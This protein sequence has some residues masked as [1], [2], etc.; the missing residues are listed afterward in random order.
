MNLNF[1]ASDTP[2]LPSNA[3]DQ[4]MALKLAKQAIKMSGIASPPISVN[5]VVKA[6]QR[7]GHK[8]IVKSTPLSDGFSG[9]II[10][11]P[12][13]TGIMY[14]STHSQHR[15]RYTVAHELGHFMMN[16][17]LTATYKEVVNLKNKLK[18]EK[19]ANIFAAELL[20]PK[21][22]IKNALKSRKYTAKELATL[23]DVSEEAMWFKIESDSLIKYL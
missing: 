22:M 21:E 12:Q 7:F 17:I 9:Q 4:P 8:I 1:E 6:L 11:M 2:S 14:N 18:I 23:F 15:Q 13:I 10:Q 19:E 20:M 3:P 16:H 5:E